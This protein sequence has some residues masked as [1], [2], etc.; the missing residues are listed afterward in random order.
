MVFHPFQVVEELDEP[1]GEAVVVVVGRD[2]WRV[3]GQW[4]EVKEDRE[5]GMN[6]S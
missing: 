6:W 1:E 3:K 2:V 5:P 4:A